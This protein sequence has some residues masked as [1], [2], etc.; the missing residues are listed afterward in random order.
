M[1]HIFKFYILVFSIFSGFPI[2]SSADAHSLFNSSEETLGDY[3]VQIATQPEF[4]QIGDKSQILIRVTDTDYNEV[5]R[6]TMGMR[7]FFNEEQI[8]AVRPQSIDGAHFNT[9]FVFYDSG[10]HIF[11]VDLYDATD[12]GQLL[13]FTFNL[14]TQSP[15]GYIFISAIAAGGIIFAGVIG[16]IFI[17][18]IIKRKSKS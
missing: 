8:N 18:K 1:K 17:P 9:D 10:N 15:F 12:D 13:T 11:R 16:I 14:S 4:P 7:I 3:R 5:E 6:F 2:I